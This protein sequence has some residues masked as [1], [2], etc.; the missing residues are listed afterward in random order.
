MNKTIN[1][2][3]TT[4]QITS[5]G[6]KV[7]IQYDNERDFDYFNLKNYSML[8]EMIKE[9]E[10]YAKEAIENEDDA[11]LIDSIH[12]VDFCEKYFNDIEYATPIRAKEEILMYEQEASEKVWFMRSVPCDDPKIEKLRQNSIEKLLTIYDDIPEEGYND[13]ECGYWNGV[14]ATLRWVLGDDEKDNLD[15]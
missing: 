6:D 10:K 8:K 2:Y 11:F 15:T 5:D 13:W 14:M 9:I 1:G 12:S 4:L 3:T 7:I